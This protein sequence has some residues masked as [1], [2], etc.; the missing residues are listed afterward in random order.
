MATGQ[1][2]VQ[3]QPAARSDWKEEA[4]SGG[5]NGA[6]IIINITITL[7]ITKM[8]KKEFQGKEKSRTG[9]G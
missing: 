1:N 5:Y 3:E 8:I 9:S 6:R 7:R 2:T 4:F